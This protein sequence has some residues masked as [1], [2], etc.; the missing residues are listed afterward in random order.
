[1]KLVVP[2]ICIFL[3]SIL[4]GQENIIHKYNH[5]AKTEQEYLY[6]N[7]LF[8]AVTEV[9]SK[10]ELY[11][12]PPSK[13]FF[14][15]IDNESELSSHMAAIHM[16]LPLSEYNLVE[17]IES[18]RPNPVIKDAVMEL[19]SYYYNSKR[20]NDAI[21]IYNDINEKLLSDVEL[22]EKC[23][24]K[25]YCYFVNKSFDYSILE[26]NKVKDSRNIFYYPVNYYLGMAHYFKKDYDEAITSFQRISGSNAYKPYLPYYIT[27]IFFAKRQFNE[28]IAY[29][30]SVLSEGSVK[31]ETEIKLLLGQAYFQRNEYTKALPYLE[32][33]ESQTDQLT[34]TEFFQLGFCQYMSKRYSDAIDNF[35]AIREVD[36][37]M[38]QTAN[39]YLADCL[40]KTGDMNSARA[41]FKK[42]SQKTFNKAMQEEAKFNYGKISAQLG[43]DRESINTLTSISSSSPYFE[44]SQMIINDVLS[45]SDDYAYVI[46]ILES[47]RSP[48]D[49]MKITYQNATLNSLLQNL[50]DGQVVEAKGFISKVKKYK[51]DK[52]YY[53]QA[54]FWESYI[55]QIESDYNK[56]IETLKEYF[57]LIS[58][59]DMPEESGMAMARYTQGYN[60][61]KNEDHASAEY[62]FKQCII[63]LGNGAKNSDLSKELLTDAF[64]RV[65]DCQFKQRAYVDAKHNYKQAEA[66]NHPEKDYAIYQRATIEGLTGNPYLKISILENLRDNFPNSE[67]RDDALMALGDTYLSL[68]NL[69]PAKL[70]YVNL[71]SGYR[72]KSLLINRAYLK[73]GLVNYNM[74]DLDRSLDYYKMVLSNKPEA[75][76]LQESITAIEEI[77]VKDRADAEGYLS[78]MESVPDIELSDFEKDSI[79]Y[80]SGINQYKNA[81][82]SDAKVAFSKY[83]KIFPE[84]FYKLEARYYRAESNLIT[85]EYGKAL[86]DYEYLIKEGLNNFYFS[87][88]KKAALIS[89]NH[90]QN[91]NKSYKYFLLYSEIALSDLNLYEANIGAMRSAFRI[92]NQE[93]V[94]K[95]ASFIIEN[96]KSSSEDKATA[97]FYIGKTAFANSNYERSLSSFGYLDR[98]MNNNMAA[99]SRYLSAKILFKTDQ[100]EAAEKQCRRLMDTSASYPNWIAKGL[101]L[102]SDINLVNE[103]FLNGKA[104]LEA[105]IENFD[106]NPDV[107]AE[108]RQK[109]EELIEKEKEVSR[110]KTTNQEG[111]LELD[112]TG[113]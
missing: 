97:H 95:H 5:D 69:E 60:F 84:G 77:M 61:L 99:E 19:G 109:L 54:L 87:S 88:V 85:K 91:F 21:N 96:N 90:L 56:S 8:G 78:F 42:V 4:N 71:I 51:L 16:E 55:Y 17:F 12:L 73:M 57:T 35:L 49:D 48:T 67:F 83:L 27:Q 74:G 39:Y 10:R 22:S 94:Y 36:N 76:E 7:N 80:S 15:R 53:G 58:G 23:F 106:E 11:S 101:I 41:A 72:D 34:E 47:L 103:D 31:K 46:R 93:G 33:Y 50:S 86:P 102:L 75:A 29:G 24:K 98:N 2:L 44:E 14:E 3:T 92:S 62:Q 64:L 63:E 112:T 25:G 30:E 70:N 82:Y 32:Y 26:L 20:Y 18:H 52:G 45:G 113:N 66:R 107:V 28:L 111:Q 105:V 9:H 79:S 104:A 100:I 37:E 108:A 89:Y 43:F 13:H 65:A 6:F 81:S 68:G 110:L 38:G 40:Q 1:M 59:V